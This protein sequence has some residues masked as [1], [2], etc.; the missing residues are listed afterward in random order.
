[1]TP[2]SNVKA[3]TPL[4]EIRLAEIN[5]I[6]SYFRPGM[7]V[8]ELGGKTGYQAAILA[9]WGCQVDSWDIESSTAQTGSAYYPVKIYDGRRLPVPDAAYDA[10]YSSHMLYWEM[11]VL[12]FFAEMRRGLKPDGPAGHILPTPAWRAL[13][14]TV[15]YPA[16]A[17][18]ISKKLFSLCTRGKSSQRRESAQAAHGE[19]ASQPSKNKRPPLKNILRPGPLG[20]GP[21]AWS[22]FRQWRRKAL[23]RLFDERGFRVEAILPLGLVYSGFLLFEKQLSPAWRKRL[24]RCWGSSS[25]AYVTRVENP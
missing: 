20:P 11:H 21:G 18:L 8:L 7:K 12:E 10:I 6:R 25:A 13:T 22:E 3:R 4:E 5:Q 1:M 17:Y 14:C 23:I 9:S 16:M 15:H 19:N 2:F 24:N